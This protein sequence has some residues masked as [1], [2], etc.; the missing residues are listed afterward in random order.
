MVAM[1]VACDPTQGLHA[2]KP[3]ESN[4]PA[5]PS[6]PDWRHSPSSQMRQ[7]IAASIGAS[8]SLSRIIHLTGG[9]G[10]VLCMSP[11][12]TLPR[13]RLCERLAHSATPYMPRC[14]L[15]SIPVDL[16]DVIS[17]DCRSSISRTR[18]AG[19]TCC[20]RPT[21]ALGWKKCPFSRRFSVH[22]CGT[23]SRSQNSN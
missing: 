16:R 12:R 10:A 14:V 6:P 2:F 8:K 17:P 5:L 18:A 22:V 15:Q 3:P 9:V 13:Q 7:T 11:C 4:A 19:E 21:A 1:P 23:G 20:S